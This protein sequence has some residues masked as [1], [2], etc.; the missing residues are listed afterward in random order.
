M[1]IGIGPKIKER[2][3]ALIKAMSFA[4]DG[5]AKTEPLAYGSEILE[6]CFLRQAV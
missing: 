6:N 1:K 5:A 2:N 4:P 3:Q